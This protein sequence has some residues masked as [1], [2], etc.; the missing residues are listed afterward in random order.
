MIADFASYRNK[1]FASNRNQ[2]S[3]QSEKKSLQIAEKFASYHNKNSIQIEAI[4]QIEEFASNRT[5]NRSISQY[6]FASYQRKFI[7]ESDIKF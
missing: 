2:N 1:K 3:L 5:E 4:L 7:C 6:K